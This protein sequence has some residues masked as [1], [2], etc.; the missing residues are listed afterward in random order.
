MLLFFFVLFI[1]FQI[2]FKKN[3]VGKK[4]LLFDTLL[5]VLNISSTYSILPY[6]VFF[7]YYRAVNTLLLTLV[8]VFYLFYR[9]RGSITYYR[10]DYLFF[11]FLIINISNII[12]GFATSTFGLGMLP[13][14]FANTTFYLLLYNLFLL[15]KKK[16]SVKNARQLLFRGYLWFCLINIFIVFS[17]FLLIKVIDFHPL[18]NEV[19]GQYDLFK[20]NIKNPNV[21]YYFPL[22]LAVIEKTLTVRIPYF[23]EYGIITGLFHEPH[24]FTFVVVPSIFLLFRE[25]KSKIAK[26]LLILIYLIVMLIEASTTNILGMLFC[27]FVLFAYNYRKQIWFLFFGIC[28]GILLFFLL[29]PTY[30]QF[31]IQKL[32]SGSRNYTQAMIEFAFMP[33]TFFGTSFFNLGYIKTYWNPNPDSFLNVGVLNFVLNLFF[34]ILLIKKIIKLI[35]SIDF[36]VRLVGIFALY[37]F[38]HSMKIVM[39]TYSLSYLVFIIFILNI[40]TIKKFQR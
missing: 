20:Y 10:N 26:V 13:F 23:Q 7:Q 19:A 3:F 27:T 2:V 38:I 29:E 35:F 15:Y 28:V 6:L 12:I 4:N 25:I 18:V 31:I 22:G 34:L 30:Y 9:F 33:K 40:F 32:T 16:T 36:E 1:F 21:S 5:I 11:S 37:F 17:L 39:F 14:M 8:N 24:T